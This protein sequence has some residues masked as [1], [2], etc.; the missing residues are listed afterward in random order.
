MIVGNIPPFTVGDRVRCN[1][2][3]ELNIWGDMVVTEVWLSDTD[4]WCCICDTEKMDDG[5]F[6]TASELE[7]I[8]E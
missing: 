1:V 7:R 3:S 8:E 6:F 5:V 2:T 4:K